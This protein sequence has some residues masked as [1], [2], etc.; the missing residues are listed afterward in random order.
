MIFKG[1]KRVIF[2]IGD[3]D[4]FKR[5]TLTPDDKRIDLRLSLSKMTFTHELSRVLLIEQLH[6]VIDLLKGG[7]YHKE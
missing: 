2:F 5:Y 7:N 6:R 3:F 4:G 1:I